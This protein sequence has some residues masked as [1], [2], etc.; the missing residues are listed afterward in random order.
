[1]VIAIASKHCR[2]AT[3]SL[4]CFLGALARND[5]CERASHHSEP[6]LLSPLRAKPS[7]EGGWRLRI[8]R[9]RWDLEI[10]AD[11]LM[12][13]TPFSITP[14]ARLERVFTG[15]DTLSTTM[16]WVCHASRPT[17]QTM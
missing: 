11:I 6:L 9:A 10:Y 1:M 17:S 15:V 3:N 13:A 8:R 16:K 4:D 2:A 7:R 12:P 14:V 5:G